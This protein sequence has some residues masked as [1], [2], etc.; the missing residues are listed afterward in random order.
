MALWSNIRQRRLFQIV[1]AYAAAGWIVLQAVDQLADNNL[2]PRLSYP[3]A[4][5]WYAGGFVAAIVIG[6]FH[7]ERGNQKAPP[8]EIG[9]L[10]GLAAGLLG[11]SAVR[12]SGYLAERS[13]LH[14][15]SV[16]RLDLRRIAVAYFDDSAPDQPNRHIADAFT[17]ELIRELSAVRALD[18]ISPNGVA[19]FRNAEIAPDS[20]ATLVQA[21][22][23][24]DGSIEQKGDRLRVHVRVFDGESGAEFRRA[25]FETP[26]GALLQTRDEIVVTTARLLREWLG[27]EIQLRRREGDTRS[28][29]AWAHVQRAEKLVKDAEAL[30]RQH[31]LTHALQ[32]FH[33]ADGLLSRAEA[34]D[35]SWV[36]PTILRTRLAYR[37]SRLAHDPEDA[38]PWI[39][40]GL[41]HAERALAR[42]P[43]HARALELRGT[44]RYWR[45]LLPLRHAGPPAE[46]L[47]QQARSD[48]EQA[49][50]RNPEL[51]SAYA[52]LSHLYFWLDDLSSG[53][54]AAQRAYEEDA[55]LETADVVLWRLVTGSYDLEQF[56]SAARW[57]NEGYRRF[58]DD[59]RFSQ[60]RLLAMTTRAAEAD[61]QDG[62]RLIARI[63]SVVPEPIRAVQRARSLMY[64][65]GVLARSGMTDSAD[66][67]L[68]TA[69][70]VSRPDVDPARELFLNE[71]AM[72]ANLMSDIDVVIELLK[73][74]AVANPGYTFEH[75]WWWRGVRSHPR[76]QELTV[77][78]R[79]AH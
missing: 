1:A 28:P 12:V 65:G 30:I 3:L 40:V 25:T 69:R 22:T 70:E 52:T 77:L 44:L 33:G 4:F 14:A 46:V 23:I 72:R 76:Y 13:A 71:A 75:H 24:V 26:A 59:Y 29:A 8:V 9:I 47:L 51:A 73:R 50:R 42:A 17:E 7:G 64:L 79:S 16:S 58:P 61:V 78:Q 15:A 60:C 34:V 5:A 6:W 66:A 18:V 67:V 39:E 31:D 19:P 35:T 10:A 36:E 2:L 63:D 74:Y 53:V 48:L 54:L 20:L 41:A 21:G 38:L 32:L 49:V 62:W 45:Q 37:R 11:F 57:C 55:F 68:R 43:H 56:E 27:A